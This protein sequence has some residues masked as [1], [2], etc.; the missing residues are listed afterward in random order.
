MTTRTILILI[1][2]VSGCSKPTVVPPATPKG[3]V[4]KPYRYPSREEQKQDLVVKMVG[5]KQGD[6]IEDVVKKVGHSFSTEPY[7]IDELSDKCGTRVIYDITDSHGVYEDIVLWFGND[8]RLLK[9]TTSTEEK[10]FAYPRKLRTEQI[11]LGK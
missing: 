11:G 5:V 3:V 8:D 4:L 1:A 2:I 6:K 9:A 7:E 10:P